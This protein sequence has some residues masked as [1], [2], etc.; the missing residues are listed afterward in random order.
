MNSL[1]VDHWESDMSTA[2]QARCTFTML[3]N[4]A[5]GAGDLNGDSE[6][7]SELETF[8]N[9]T[10]TGSILGLAIRTRSK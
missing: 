10:G 3:C 8:Y 9:T 1:P 7:D 2:N 5:F 6:S 4:A